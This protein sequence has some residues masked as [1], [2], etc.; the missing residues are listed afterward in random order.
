MLLIPSN[1]S[2]VLW[3]MYIL[4]IFRCALLVKQFPLLTYSPKSILFII[5]F[6]MSLQHVHCSEHIWMLKTLIFSSKSVNQR[7]SVQRTYRYALLCTFSS[8]YLVLVNFGTC[9]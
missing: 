8:R 7:L 4:P 2:L 1:N 6:I 3:H 9:K 5:I